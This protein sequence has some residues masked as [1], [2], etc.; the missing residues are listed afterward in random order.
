MLKAEACA[1]AQQGFVPRLIGRA[2]VSI[3][4]PV[5]LAPRSELEPDL[6][7]WRPG[8]DRYREALP[9]PEDVLLLVELADTTLPYDRGIKLPLYAAAGIPEFWIV[10]LERRRVL[11][12]RAP[13]S[14]MYREA[15]IVDEGTLTPVAFPDLAI[16]LEETIG[17]AAACRPERLRGC[18]LA[19]RPAA[20]AAG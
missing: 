7:L 4:N 16:G 15:C 19:G 17:W 18:R 9:G 8:A 6:L 12:H 11:V 10:D 3:Q 5:R 1:P 20:A 14:D 2:I 13:A